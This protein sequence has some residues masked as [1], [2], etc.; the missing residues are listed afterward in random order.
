MK[1]TIII[2]KGKERELTMSFISPLL[3]QLL[4]I[5]GQET[6][7]DLGIDEA[8]VMTDKFKKSIDKRAKF[9]SKAVN[10]TTFRKLKNTL[11]EG[12]EAGEGYI[13]L[14]DRVRGVYKDIGDYRADLIAR[15]ESTNANNEGT[16]AGYNQS[17]IVSHKEWIAI[18]DDRTRPEHA[19]MNGE[20][21]P[22]DALFS[23]GLPY[24][25]EPNC[26]CAIG[27]AVED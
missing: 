14:S 23:N 17:K 13:A 19:E 18:M 20:I 27:P 15:T 25:Q 7:D 11:S 4:K 6:L 21:V 1:Y 24:P 8:F 2:E 12:L 3:T 22:K 5:A 10:N 16:L 9:F 26:R